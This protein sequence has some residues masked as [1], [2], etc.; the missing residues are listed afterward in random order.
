MDPV[1]GVSPRIPQSWNRYS[2]VYN[3][4]LKHLDPT[5]MIVLVLDQEVLDLI[6]GTLPEETHN[7]VVLN[8]QGAIDASVLEKAGSGNSNYRDLLALAKADQSVEISSSGG[9]RSRNHGNG[10]FFFKSRAQLI[11]ELTPV[12][13]GDAAQN[14]IKGPDTFLG[15]TIEPADSFSGILSVII[16]DGQGQAS[17]APLA[18]R[19]VTTAHE[20]YGHALLFVVGKPW[21]HDGG[22]PVDQAIDQIEARTRRGLE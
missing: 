5:G 15:F 7:F 10:S 12:L 18:E 14:E 22:G 2:Y 20:L 11:K 19:L 17:T 9:Y 13:G 16:S 8:G 1:T 6:K 3:N 4:P 21:K